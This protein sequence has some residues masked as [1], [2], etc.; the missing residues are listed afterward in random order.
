[1][2]QQSQSL[3]VTGCRLLVEVLPI[4]N[5]TG[6]QLLLPEEFRYPQLQGIVRGVG[7]DCSEFTG[8]VGDMVMFDR[9]S[10]NTVPGHPN[11]I[12]IHEKNILGVVA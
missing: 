5:G 4:D 8:Q 6:G 2:S 1:M 7:R 12:I 3:R 9:H 10:G 11:L